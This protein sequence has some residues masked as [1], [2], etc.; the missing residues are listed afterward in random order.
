M[1]HRS[2]RD[3]DQGGRDRGDRPRRGDRDTREP[4]HDRGERDSGLNEFFVDG[5]GIHREVM[6]REICKYLGPEAWSRPSVYNVGPSAMRRL[7]SN[8]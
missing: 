2:D 7:K 3:R 4:G 8:H 1:A 6:Q 5:E